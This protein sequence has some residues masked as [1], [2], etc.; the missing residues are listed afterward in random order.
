VLDPADGSLLRTIG[1]TG[2]D[3]V[4]GIDFDPTTGILYGVTNGPGRLLVLD[5]T[6]GAGTV[7]GS[8]GAQIPD[9][10]FDPAGTLYGWSSFDDDLVTIDLGTGQATI[11]GE[12]SCPTGLTGLAAD[13]AG[14]LYM[15]S[16]ETLHVLEP[17]TGTIV[18]TTPIPPFETSNPLEF[19][20]RDVL[21]SGLRTGDGF[22]LRTLDQ[23]TGELTSLGS[24]ALAFLSGIAISGGQADRDRDGIGDRCDPCPH[25]PANDADGDGLCGAVD[26]CPSVSSSDQTDTDGDGVGDLCDNCV[27]SPN[28]TQ[29]D[30]DGDGLGNACDNCPAV[31]NVDQSDTDGDDVGQVCDNCPV[32]PNPGDTSG[33]EGVRASLDADHPTITAL[34][35]NLF[36]FADGA[37]GT[38]IGDGGND[39]YDGGNILNTNRASA[40]P[41]TN[42][43]I[44]GADTAF[45]PG[46]RYFTAKYPGLFVMAAVGISIE[47]FSIT[48]NNGADGAGTVDGAVLTVPG[49]SVFVKRVYGTSDPSINHIVIVPGASAGVTHS[50]AAS[51]DNDLQTITG[52]AGASS[53]YYVLVARSNGGFLSNEQ[54]TAIARAFPTYLGQPDRDRDGTGDACDPCPDDPDNDADGDGLCGDIDNCPLSANVDQADADLDGVGDT[55]DNCVEAPNPSQSDPDGD[56]LGDACD[57]CPSVLNTDQSD[58]DGDGLGSACDNCPDTPNSSGGGVMYAVD[59]ASGHAASL[60]VLDTATGALVRTIGPTGFNHVTSI[61]IDPT[62]GI[63]YGVKNNPDQLIVLD[64]TTGMGMVLGNTGHQVPDIAFS[65]TGVLY[66]WSETVDDL[67]TI[68]LATGLATRVGECFCTTARTGVAFDSAG[69]LYMKSYATLHTLDPLTGRI[70]TTVAIPSDQTHNVLEFDPDDVLYTGLRTGGGFSLRR[71]NRTT[72]ALAI[73]GSSPLA[74]LSGIAVASAQLDRDR[75]GLGDAC[76]TCP[77]DPGNDVDADVVCGDVDNCPLVAN[78]DQTDAD[79]DGVGDTC[80]N[81]V[82]APNPSQSDPD[83]DGLGDACDNCSQT[84]NPGQADGDGDADGDACDRCPSIANPLQQ[85]TLACLVVDADGGEC[86]AARIE[87]IEADLTGEIR[88]FA[89]SGAP[90]ES[91]TFEIL[92]TSC[93]AAD[94]LELSLN[95]TLLGSTVLDPAVRCACSPGVQTFAVTDGALLASLWQVGGTNTIRM[96]K[97]STGSALAWVRARFDA[98]GVSVSDCLFDVD[99]G[100]CAA[101]DL[102]VAGFSSLALDEA[103]ATAAQ[104]PILEFLVRVTPFVGGLLPASIDL[105][106]LPD[107]PS[108][109]CVMA[110]GT[111][112]RD[113]VSF[114]KAGQADLALNGAACRPPVAIARA[115]SFVECESPLGATVLLDGTGS[116]DPSSTPGTHDGIVRFDWLESSGPG[117]EAV[118]GTGE[119]LS[120]TLPLGVHTITLRVTD[121]L[122]QTDE[123]TIVV[124]V[125]DTTAPAISVGLSSDLLWPPNHRMIDVTASLSAADA[126]STPTVVLDAVSSNEPDDG[127]GDGDT[128]DDIQN[129]L[130]DT[131]DSTLALRAERR[132]DGDGRIYTITYTATDDAGNAT[133]AARYVL[134]PHDLGGTVDPIRIALASA[135]AGTVVSWGPVPG[136][137][138]YNVIRGRLADIV[139]A[140]AFINLG[141]VA[142]IDSASLDTST[143]G[144]EDPELPAAGQAFFYLVEYD[145]GRASS[146]GS[147][148]SGAPQVPASGA[149][150]P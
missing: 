98:G 56:G 76:D 87:S 34:V 67:V 35:P 86:F 30:P 93:L 62:T 24:N 104:L 116:S 33:I 78:A 47:S 11:V 66:G 59:G 69:T 36:L 146:Y 110:P 9:I 27:G 130:L 109:V 80:D 144:Q 124:T 16:F 25:D 31:A 58:P 12:C 92:A 131:A 107:G 143:E 14:T 114:E 142:C 117:A 90:P 46:S 19:D 43:A 115:E 100:T 50:F 127:E 94:T 105:A 23:G 111:A 136:A 148:S 20:P 71:L 72:G 48:G 83:G 128:I 96:R 52:L 1:P 2:Y 10:T 89:L 3:H 42:G 39:M 113:C 102:C 120:L 21:F 138:H 26:N 79:F 122:G 82:E 49:A 84:V 18:S 118:L 141:S 135:S 77:L 28:P 99:G 132:G 81:C 147:E 134:V 140:G 41:Y 60:H 121:A 125:Q 137:R 149:C 38:S 145:D 44:V 51:T 45:G 40:I 91:I 129:A 103:R 5:V 4:T 73:V 29:V 65:P 75:D 32:D 6:T 68:D 97:S 95:G 133:P 22:S 53:I 55:C 126:C 119:T 112:A 123:D 101:L 54:I 37:T 17:S 13:S 150:G 74:F 7:I 85:E 139:H 63:L 64:T 88:L 108:R 61:D 70:L 15:K 57:N 106:D 8:T